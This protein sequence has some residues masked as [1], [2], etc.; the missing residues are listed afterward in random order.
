MGAVDDLGF[1]GDELADGLGVD[2]GD[3]AEAGEGGF[4]G[5]G[6]AGDLEFDD[7]GGLAGP[8]LEG[9]EGDVD[10]AVFVAA[11]FERGGGG[12]GDG[13]VVEG[14]GGFGGWVGAG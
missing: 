13:L 14:E 6:T 9:F 1:A 7:G 12:E 3:G 4:Y 8:L 2:A 10:A 5:G 11:G